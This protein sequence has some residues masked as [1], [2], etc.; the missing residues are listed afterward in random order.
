MTQVEALHSLLSHLDQQK[1]RP[2]SQ[3]AFHHWQITKVTGGMNNLV[4]RAMLD[5]NEF[6]VKFTIQD[7]RKRA[8]RE[9]DALYALKEAGFLLAPQ[10]ILLDTESYTQ[11]VVVQ[12]W[13]QGQRLETP[14]RSDIEWRKLIDHFLAIHGLTANESTVHLPEAVINCYDIPS[15]FDLVYNHLNLIPP[16]ERPASLTEII[17]KL[18]QTTFPQWAKTTPVL[19]R[20]DANVLNII[21]TTREWRSVDWENSGWGDPAFE[22]AD[23]ITHPAYEGVSQARWHWV[24][25][26]YCA[27]TSDPTTADRIRIYTF[28]MLVWWVVRITRY[29]YE[30]PRGKDMR[31]VGGNQ[32]SV[33][34]QAKRQEQFQHYLDLAWEQ[35]KQDWGW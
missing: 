26:Y 34:W 21:K 12:S 1:C 29:L 14:P 13:I 22:V 35:G 2:D 8:Q 9:Y 30:V 19:C 16:T 4:Y 23:I 11:P 31:L 5:T 24:V 28:F 25:E 32:D 33:R 18:S 7:K 10:P 20:V 17:N 3:W 15:S 27:R 6:A